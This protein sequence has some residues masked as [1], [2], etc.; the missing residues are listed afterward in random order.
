MCC[1]FASMPAAIVAAKQTIMQV[2]NMLVQKKCL[3]RYAEAMGEARRRCGSKLGCACGLPGPE[4]AGVP[5]GA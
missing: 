1:V 2:Q 5:Q 4:R 3:A